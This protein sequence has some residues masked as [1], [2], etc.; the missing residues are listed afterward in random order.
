MS[1]NIYYIRPSKIEYN[2]L[3]EVSDGKVFFLDVLYPL[4]RKQ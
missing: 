2:Y 1:I 3:T 4:P